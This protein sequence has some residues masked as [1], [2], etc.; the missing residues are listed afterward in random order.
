MAMVKKVLFIGVVALV[1]VAATRLV[2]IPVVS[3]LV[4]GKKA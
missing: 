3:D 4:N 2:N 1:F